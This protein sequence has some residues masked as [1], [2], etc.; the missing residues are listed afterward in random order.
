MSLLNYYEFSSSENGEN[1][2]GSRIPFDVSFTS[3]WTRNVTGL[4]CTFVCGVKTK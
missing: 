1:A 3:Y 2:I 4:D